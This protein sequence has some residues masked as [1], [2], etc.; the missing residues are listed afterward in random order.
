VFDRDDAYMQPTTEL[1]RVNY[2]VDDLN[3][4]VDETFEE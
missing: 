4:L 2:R 1:L 3:A